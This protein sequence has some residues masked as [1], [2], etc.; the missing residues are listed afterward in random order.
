MLSRSQA[1]F[2]FLA[3]IA[4]KE[5]ACIGVQFKYLANALTSRSTSLKMVFEMASFSSL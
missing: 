4:T 1:L 3:K 2:D 5:Q